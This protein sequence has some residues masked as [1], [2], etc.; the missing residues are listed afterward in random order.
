M[1]TSSH[2]FC[3]HPESD[4]DDGHE[5]E[6]L[7]DPTDTRL[8]GERKKSYCAGKVLATKRDRPQ[9]D[10]DNDPTLIDVRR[11][12]RRRSEDHTMPTAEL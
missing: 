1:S 6:G 2:N 4:E 7:L 12:R 11:A 3:T 8:P 10:V 9:S 5:D